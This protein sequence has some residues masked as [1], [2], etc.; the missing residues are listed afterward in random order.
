MVCKM[1]EYDYHKKMSIKVIQKIL[2]KDCGKRQHL[3][4]QVRQV[5][6]DDDETSFND[7]DFIG[8]PGH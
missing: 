6:N 4:R 3:S 2:R 7:L 5:A 1:Y 8:D